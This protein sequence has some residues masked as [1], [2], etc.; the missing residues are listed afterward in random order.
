MPSG[1][2]NRKKQCYKILISIHRYFLYFKRQQKKLSVSENK[3]LKCCSQKD[4]IIIVSQVK[5]LE[6]QCIQQSRL[7]RDFHWVRAPRAP[8]VKP[9]KEKKRNRKEKHHMWQRKRIR[10][11]TDNDGCGNFV[12]LYRFLFIAPLPLPI[13]TILGN[14]QKTLEGERGKRAEIKFVSSFETDEQQ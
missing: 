11:T 7:G 1:S 9:G 3:Q 14:H 10:F 2:E 6:R 12:L 5:Q 4:K 8:K 13:M